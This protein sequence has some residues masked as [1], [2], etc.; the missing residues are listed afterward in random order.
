[1]MKSRFNIKQYCIIITPL[2]LATSWRIKKLV[3]EIMYNHPQAVEHVNKKGRNILHVVKR[4]RELA[5]LLFIDVKKGFIQKVD[6]GYT[7]V[8]PIIKL[9]LHISLSYN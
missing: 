1:M 9:R 4:K 5:E 2:F 3:E 6:L 8:S 7:L